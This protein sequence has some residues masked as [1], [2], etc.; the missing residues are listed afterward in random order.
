MLCLLLYQFYVF[1][2]T[3]IYAYIAC[4]KVNLYHF[5]SKTILG[6]NRILQCVSKGTRKSML[7]GLQW[8]NAINITGT[9]HITVLLSQKI[10]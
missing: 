10:K 3:H 4:N 7:H 2:F 9:F 1:P 5:E 6:T 8:Q